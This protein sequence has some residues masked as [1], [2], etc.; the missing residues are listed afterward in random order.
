MFKQSKETLHFISKAIDRELEIPKFS[1]PYYEGF[2]KNDNSYWLGI[3]RRDELFSVYFLI[4]VCNICMQ[5]KI[6]QLYTTS[7]KSII[8][9]GIEN[10]HRNLW[11]Y[12]LGTYRINVRH[13]ANELNWQVEDNNE[14]GLMLKRHVIRH[15]DKEDVRTYG[16]SFAVKT[17][18]SSS[19]FGSVII[20]K[21][22]SKNANRLKS[23]DRF[24]I[25]Y[26]TDFNPNS[27]LY[28]VFRKDVEKDYL[29]IY[30]VS[31]CK[32]FYERIGADKEVVEVENT[33]QSEA[34]RQTEQLI[35]QCKHCLTTY[36][37]QTGEPEN[38]I[39]EGTPFTELP[40]SYCCSLCNSPKT[41]FKAIHLGTLELKT[42]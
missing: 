1:L 42:L 29:G 9:K 41:D 40:E 35:Y 25:L 21:Q 34:I 3:Y 14:E 38:G 2:N 22:Q 12:V 30:L 5:T 27:S 36:N 33:P 16:L 26:T 15:F 20:R 37:Q 39:E 11:D 23:L 6:G 24:D 19:M 4:D 28:K 10:K 13:A 32:F 8:I 17:K 18:A 31:L 7:W